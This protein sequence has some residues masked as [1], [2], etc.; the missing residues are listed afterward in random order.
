[1]A[2]QD[3]SAFLHQTSK[4]FAQT[5]EYY[6]SQPEWANQAK[7]LVSRVYNRIN[8]AQLACL[9]TYGFIIIIFI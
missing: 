7:L 6:V 1:M 2:F 8:S 5:L 3:P 9:H 4:I